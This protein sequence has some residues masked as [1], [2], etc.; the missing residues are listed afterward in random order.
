[1]E[2]ICDQCGETFKL[3]LGADPTHYFKY[4]GSDCGGWGR[5]IDRET[6]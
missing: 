3:E 5:K 4:D 1:M 2:A 6:K